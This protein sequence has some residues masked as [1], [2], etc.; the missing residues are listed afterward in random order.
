MNQKQEFIYAQNVAIGGENIRALF[1][2]KK[3]KLREK[4][5]DVF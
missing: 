1:L 2:F 4:K 5:T 3:E